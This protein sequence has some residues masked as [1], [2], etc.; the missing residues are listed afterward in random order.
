M[1]SAEDPAATVRYPVFAA[2]GSGSSSGGGA[3]GGSAPP[4]SG[5]HAIAEVLARRL[6]MR[7]QGDP[8]LNV[9]F[10]SAEQRQHVGMT[11]SPYLRRAAFSSISWGPRDPTPALWV[12]T[13]SDVPD[14]EVTARDA[15]PH[16][17]TEPLLV[18]GRGYL[19][20]RTGDPALDRHFRVVT[21]SPRFVPLLRPALARLAGESFVHLFS[22]Q[23]APGL[24]ASLTDGAGLPAVLRA[25]ED[26]LYALELLACAVEGRQPPA[27]RAAS[28]A[29]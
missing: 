11:G 25:A 27:M 5:E 14:F 7:L 6:G 16:L 12:A 20:A 13:S 8:A 29:P 24:I 26:H 17:R 21:T 19:E 4:P 1:R 18:L 15:A 22:S 23:R 2:S 28:S 9:L 3:G 10:A